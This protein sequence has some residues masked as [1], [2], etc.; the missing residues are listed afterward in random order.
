[1][2][3]GQGRLV[4]EYL[5]L[6]GGETGLKYRDY[7]WDQGDHLIKATTW[8]KPGAAAATK[9]AEVGYFYDAEG[10]RTARMVNT[11]LDGAVGEWISNG[12]GDAVTL[13]HYIGDDEVVERV[14]DNA[15]SDANAY[16]VTRRNYWGEGD[17]QLLGYGARPN[18]S[19]SNYEGF[20]A[21]LDEQSSVRDVVYSNNAQ[22]LFSIDYSDF[23][24]PV[25]SVAPSSVSHP[26]FS[27]TG[28]WQDPATGLFDYSARWYDAVVRP[29]PGEGSDLKF[30]I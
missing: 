22:R 19:Y 7:L 4:R 21:G 20:F 17:N 28:Q 29:W 30:Q 6:A 15:W 5:P 23:G 12:V 27:Y 11:D 14:R 26:G 18:G 1:M 9:V 24:T 10:R 16:T 25:F 2:H 8:Y 3:D 13:Y